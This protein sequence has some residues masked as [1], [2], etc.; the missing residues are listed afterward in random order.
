M[1]KRG[2]KN[3]STSAAPPPEPQGPQAQSPA[4]E[5]RPRPPLVAV[6][7]GVA[8]AAA[9]AAFFV[10]SSS[11][12]PPASTPQATSGPL[13]AGDPGYID[14]AVCA[15]CHA[16][17]AASYAETGMARAFYQ[18]N[19]E[20]MAHLPADP[21]YSHAKSGRSY[22]IDRRDGAY[23]LRRHE[24]APDGSEINVFEKR[25]DF[26]MGSGNHA[27]TYLHRYPTGKMVELP[28]GWYAENGGRLAMSPGY[29]QPAHNGFRREIPF[30]CMFCHNGYSPI[31]PGSDAPGRDPL[32][33]GRL[34]EGIG[35]QRCHGPGRAHVDAVANQEPDAQVRQAIFNPAGASRER[36]LEVCM[37]CHLESTAR[38]LPYSIRRFDRAAFSYRPNEPLSDYVLHFDHPKGVREDKFEIAHAAYRLRK[39]ACFERSEMTC[40]SCH[41]PHQVWR[42]AEARERFSA[43]CKSCHADAA[44]REVAGHASATDCIDCHMPQRRTEDVVGVVMTDH[45]I[46]RRPPQQDQT[47]PLE[48]AVEGPEDLYQG[49]VAAYY[50]A[51]LGSGSAEDRLYLAT[52]QVYE[53]SNLAAAPQLERLIEEH[54]PPQAG[55]YFQMAESYWNRKLYAESLE[56]YEQAI[57]RDPRHLVALRNYGVALEQVGRLSEAEAVLRKALA[58]APDDPEALTNIANVL[59]DQQRPGDAAVA[60]ERSLEQ[61]PDSPEAL[62]A[63]ARA[64]DALGNTPGGVEAARNAVRV[65]PDYAQGYNTLGNL[66]QS[67]G[68]AGGAER[69]FR[70]SLE[71]D[72]QYAAAHYNY[73][74]FFG[75]A[76]RLPEAE[77]EVRRAIALDP[78]LAAAHNSL[79]SLLG[80]RGDNRAA[81]QSFRRALELDPR[82]AEAHFNLGTALA[83][84]NRLDEAV[85]RFRTTLDLAPDYGQARAN[86]AI[87][88]A[89]SGDLDAARAE[90]ARIRD[91]Q[92]RARAEEMMRQA[93]Q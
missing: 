72:P 7:F 6:L 8:A 64:R 75:A 83:A 43:A 58:T 19:D 4:S 5:M 34:V 55:F 86:L 70:R 23:Y 15:G 82:M 31:E 73:G 66:L 2:R 90:T 14:N 22:R 51:D 56:W 33:P 42:G 10:Y 16:E 32:F 45:Y 89:V 59:L 63:L 28:L 47:A 76:D 85:Q 61:D 52:A 21:S 24:T 74:L 60:L 77:R 46:Q 92:L 87:T 54:Q 41:D 20:S 67:S 9:V 37:Q 30:E 44:L 65:K 38:R 93:A 26:V 91:P 49:E 81:E 57:A 50:P 68:D 17:I 3:R 39:S 69:A 71:L 62:Q 11:E 78:K 12:A 13:I 1:A 27:R 18:A 88:L 80:M 79:G 35:C 53:T 84:Q 29:D 25:I 48:E 40:T 36:R